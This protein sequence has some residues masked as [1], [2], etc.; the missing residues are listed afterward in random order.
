M[1]TTTSVSVPLNS[2]KKMIETFLDLPFKN[3]KKRI[4]RLYFLVETR[5]ASCTHR[6]IWKIFRGTFTKILY[7][8]GNISV[9]LGSYVQFF[10]LHMS[11]K[12]IPCSFQIKEKRMAEKRCTLPTPN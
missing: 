8:H 12:W 4:V 9:V 3:V 1:A 6:H 11:V 2:Y 5:F 7:V 10:F